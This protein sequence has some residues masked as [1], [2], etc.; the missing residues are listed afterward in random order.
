VLVI[1]LD[2]SDPSLLRR[3]SDSGDLPVLRRLLAAGA[4]GEMETGSRQFPDSALY[5]AYTGLRPARLGRYFFIQPRR[6]VPRL[7]LIGE[8]LP[9]GEPFWVTAGRHGRRCIVVDTP[10]IGLHQPAGGVHVIGW[11][12]HGF[13]SPF[14]TAPAA[15]AGELLARHG[16]YPLDNCDDHGK[17]LR[18][19]RRL[20][21]RLLDGV[22]ARG[23][24][25][26]DLARR[27]DWDLFF[28]VFSEP[29]CAG[30][31]LWHF[32]D[33]TH[34]RH[35]P[36]PE[37]AGTLRDVY[38][39]VDAAVGALIEAVGAET[40]VVLFSSQGMR[41]QYHGRDLLTPLL[42]LWGMGEARNRA[43][44]PAHESKQCARQPRLKRLREA[45]PLPLQYVVKRHLPQRLADELLCRFIGAVVLDV[46]ARAYQV[47]NNEM[48]PAVRI[49]LA[50]RDPMGIV[51]PGQEYEALCG[52]LTARL[53]ELVN[54]ATGRAALDDVSLTDAVHP[55]ARRDVLPDL[56]GYWSAE[57]PIDALYSPGY[58]TVSGAHRDSRTGG[59]AP[60]GLLYLSGTSG[61]LQRHEIA[62]LGPTVLDLLGVPPPS[63]VDGRSLLR[64]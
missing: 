61:R 47:P 17:T 56:T 16:R 48:T 27:R 43:P 39:A 1:G 30:H 44:D 40:R 51:R 14:A 25:L 36:D 59:H 20:R 15:V 7:E 9:V 62:D 34:V 35:W 45:V 41:P 64:R 42:R 5:T 11:G 57:A 4:A 23:R 60:Q 63:D 2:A 46:G 53:R 58:G 24:L 54:P 38:A 49:N 29:H 12:T 33:P 52:F 37:L 55:G 3:W 6:D 21:R 13:R 32:H 8:D 22:A 28:A 10:K 31:N 19:Y 50:G 18:S 26:V